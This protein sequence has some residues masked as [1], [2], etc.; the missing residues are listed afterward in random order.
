MNG[1]D[2]FRRN[3]RLTLAFCAFASPVMAQDDFS[4]TVAEREAL[5]SNSMKAMEP[6]INARAEAQGRQVAELANLFLSALETIAPLPGVEIFP[7]GGEREVPIVGRDKAVSAAADWLG[8]WWEGRS[9]EQ[10]TT[11]QRELL[12]RDLPGLIERIEQNRAQVAEEQRQRDFDE[13]VRQYRETVYGPPR[14]NEFMGRYENEMHAAFGDYTTGLASS[15]GDARAVR[16]PDPELD[17]VLAT[18][19]R[20]PFTT[21]VESPS[22]ISTGGFTGE[23]GLNIAGVLNVLAF[24]SGNLQDGDQ[25]RLTVRDSRGVILSRNITLTFGGSTSRLSARRG[26]VNV[27]ITALNEGTSP[28]N[29]GGLRV[30]GDVA[31]SRRGNFNLTRGQSGTL[32]VRVLGN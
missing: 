22:G 15:I 3:G 8:D 2:I 18:D 4:V 24:D 14:P 27:T 23:E 30:S 10:I 6:E 21:T 29:T 32:A 17:R 26:L 13:Q 5:L 28:P 12:E 9:R 25:V 7:G 31:G 16:S 20:S 1:K 11:R 19:P